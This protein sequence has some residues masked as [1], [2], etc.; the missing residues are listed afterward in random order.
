MIYHTIVCLRG[1]DIV[2]S[3][4]PENKL[5]PYKMLNM[6]ADAVGTGSKIQYNLYHKQITI[7]P[8]TV[9]AWYSHCSKKYYWGRGITYHPKS[10][11]YYISSI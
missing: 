1:S 11:L 8:M 5:M 10:P 7:L 9:L 2:N 3:T 6:K 4:F